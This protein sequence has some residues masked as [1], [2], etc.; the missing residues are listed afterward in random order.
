MTSPVVRT[1]PSGP[2]GELGA[3]PYSPRELAWGGYIAT[4]LWVL[5]LG[6]A[7]TLALWSTQPYWV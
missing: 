2:A 5:A 6:L 3:G 4:A 7:A 1:L